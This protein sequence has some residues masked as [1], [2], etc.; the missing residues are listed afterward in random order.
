MKYGDLSLGQIEAL[1]NKLGGL[2]RVHQILSGSLKTTDIN[3][4]SEPE[5]EDIDEVMFDF[6]TKKTIKE[7]AISMD[8]RGCRPATKEEFIIFGEKHPEVRFSIMTV[9]ALTESDNRNACY[10]FHYDEKNKGRSAKDSCL[11]YSTPFEINTK[12][13]KF[14]GVRK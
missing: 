11:L 7:I 14:L 5:G 13:W 1:V 4:S 2:D 6:Q 10:Y 8:E 12:H 9:V 3:F